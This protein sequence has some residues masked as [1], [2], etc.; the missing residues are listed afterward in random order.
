MKMEVLLAVAVSII[1]VDSTRLV[2]QLSVQWI[3]GVLSGALA[4]VLADT[5]PP[6][7][8]ETVTTRLKCRHP[9]AS[10]TDPR[11]VP[12]HWSGP[13]L[14]TPSPSRSGLNVAVVDVAEAGMV[15]RQRLLVPVQ[16][17]FHPVKAD[18]APDIATSMTGVSFGYNVLQT[19]PQSIMYGIEITVPS[20]MEVTFRE[21]RSGAT[22][23]I[24]PALPS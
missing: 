8:P 6:P 23:G 17:P 7:I 9:V 22:L 15:K 18:S 16:A 20:P 11:G 1:S 21:N 2:V 13:S 12:K 19:Y 24:N 3:I 5:V 14:K 10:T 4:G